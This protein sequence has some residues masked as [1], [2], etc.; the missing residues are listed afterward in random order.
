V[1]V[2]LL[3][4]GSGGSADSVAIARASNV[5]IR[6]PLGQSE[7]SPSDLR[8]GRNLANLRAREVEFA[9]D[10]A[11]LRRRVLKTREII[12]AAEAEIVSQGETGTKDERA[13]FG[14]MPVQPD[15]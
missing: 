14:P 4:G 1:Q 7:D 12:Q 6:H 10:H 11:S 13:T 2:E 3:E 8:V 9:T 15:R 5:L